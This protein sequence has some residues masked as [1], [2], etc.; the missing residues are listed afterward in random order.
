MTDVKYLEK[1]GLH[2]NF[3]WDKDQGMGEMGWG[4]GEELTRKLIRL[5]MLQPFTGEWSGKRPWPIGS[6]VQCST[7]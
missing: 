1:N 2:S 4:H 6:G 3:K 5:N 7:Q